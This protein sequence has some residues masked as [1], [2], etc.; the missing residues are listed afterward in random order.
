MPVC[1]WMLAPVS[2]TERLPAAGA[3][4]G[5]QVAPADELGAT[6]RRLPEAPIGQTPERPKL[7]AESTTSS[8]PPERETWY[9]SAG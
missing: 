2:A 8:T 7:P 4:G 3:A 1:D 9:V 6:T 5:T